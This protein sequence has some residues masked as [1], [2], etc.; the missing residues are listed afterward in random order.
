MTSDA[1]G[2]CVWVPVRITSA[3]P[4]CF[5]DPLEWQVYP[6]T[7]YC[8]AYQRHVSLPQN[9]RSPG[10]L[11]HFWDPLGPSLQRV[12]CVSCNHNAGKADGVKCSCCI[13]TMS[14]ARSN[15][16]P[17]VPLPMRKLF[18]SRATWQSAPSLMQTPWRVSVVA[19]AKTSASHLL[20]H[21]QS[22]FDHTLPPVPTASS[23]QIWG[24]LR[25]RAKWQ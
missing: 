25:S 19:K 10:S 24:Q 15:P 9:L 11:N 12:R 8:L 23:L 13:L 18:T 7:A 4:R 17:S 1:V 5:P 14:R 22:A 21:S 20:Q 2:P 16:A 3:C 6:D